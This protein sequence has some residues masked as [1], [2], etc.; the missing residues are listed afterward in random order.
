MLA[1]SPNE[2]DVFEK[3]FKV[4]TGKARF[5]WQWRLFERLVGGDWPDPIAIPTGLGKTSVMAVWVLALAWEL[6]ELRRSWR[7]PRIPRRLAYVVDRR[8]VV[9]QASEEAEA[10]AK[11]LEHALKNAG[12]PLADKAGALKEA[13]CDD[14]VLAV[15]TLRGQRTLDRRW[16]LD[17]ARPAI[18][19]GTVD[20]IGSR[21][22][23][24]AYG[25]VG[26]WGRP[27][28]AG[29]LGQDCL[30]VL[31]E[32]HLS[33][34]FDDT[35]AAVEDML[36]CSK[37]LRPFAVIRMGATARPSPSGCTP[38]ELS[39]EDRENPEIQKRLTADKHVELQDLGENEKLADV[40]VEWA[41]ERAKSE[42][43]ASIG[44]VLNTVRE[45][46]AVSEQLRKRLRENG[47]P[48]D[49]VLVLTGSMRGVERDD[50]VGDEK[51]TYHRRFRAGRERDGAAGPAFLVATSCIEVGADIDLDHLATEV[52][53]LDSLVQRLGRVNRRGERSQPSPVLVVVTTEVNAVAKNVVD[54]LRN[55][56]T[57][58]PEL[59]REDETLDG[60]PDGLPRA[61]AEELDRSP[62]RRAELCGAPPPVPRL[63]RA[64]VDDLAMT[65]LT[66]DDA[67]RPDVSLWLRGCSPD[68]EGTYVEL[69]WRR[70][71]DWVSNE[72]EAASL[73]EAF[74][75]SPRETARCPLSEAVKLLERLREKKEGLLVV[76]RND[77]ARG[78]R[79]S[80][81]P[82]DE[83]ELFRLAAWS[84][85]A[86]PCSAGGYKDNFADPDSTGTVGD[87]ADKALPETWAPRQRLWIEEGLLKAG[88]PGSDG[89]EVSEAW[90]VEDAETLRTAC[91]EAARR[92]LG[93]DWD[94]VAAAGTA[95]RG[96]LVARRRRR[97]FP[98]SAE[99]DRASLG[100]SSPVA[101]DQHLQDAE[102]W[103]KSLCAKLGLGANV[104]EAIVEAARKHDLGKN[105][106]WWQ[107][108]IG[109]TD[110]ARP[111]A[112]SGRS[113]F[114]HAVNAGYR[115]ELGSLMDLLGEEES[116][117][118]LVAHLVAAHHGF[119]RPAFAP[120]AAGPAASAGASRLIAEAACRFARLHQDW[121]PWA[122]AYLEAVV[123]AADALA[124]R[125]VEP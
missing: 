22:L 91:E 79:F 81:L 60:S 24:S 98:E 108:A 102:R 121:G 30:I 38:L 14:Q 116:T 17:P 88:D 16:R 99:A 8:V 117:D 25:P 29:L 89:V 74:P 41:I 19:V 52:C 93:K 54:W 2:R 7:E 15:S 53:P 6:M 87:V 26:R 86:L 75:L 49:D 124:S 106:P 107:G 96:V 113:G 21:L 100:F 73:I 120:E 80:S 20:M 72:N 36:S 48:C 123:K 40:L 13:G 57:A 12:D 122:L 27:Y 43:G 64:T 66:L 83:A 68:D 50:V 51:R 110:A 82:Q 9:D 94:L 42:P 3:T 32:A 61:A 37:R 35:L 18:I 67:D 58:R 105:R 101:L 119:A 114:D 59:V 31:D 103:A 62:E 95:E 90:L 11:R 1:V 10:L 34:P 97:R 69:A 47:L 39:D 112:K 65:S 118:D 4:L 70:E 92:L 63:G 78:Y 76:V 71:L 46:R 44:L 115:H 55:L 111:L 56:P 28:E 5:P 104:S 109:N 77:E 45:A 125:D 23:F 85:I 33:Q 84:Q